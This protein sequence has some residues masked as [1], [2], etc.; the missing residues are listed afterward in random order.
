MGTRQSYWRVS[1]LSIFTFLYVA[2]SKNTEKKIISVSL[3][4]CYFFL[5]LNPSNL[6]AVSIPSFV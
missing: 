3:P 4:V 1:T 5:A 2:V 6:K